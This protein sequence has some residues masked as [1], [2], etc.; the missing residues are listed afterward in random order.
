[1][2]NGVSQA[3]IIRSDAKADGEMSNLSGQTKYFHSAATATHDSM[4]SLCTEDAI[5]KCRH[6]PTR[7]VHSRRLI[8][9]ERSYIEMSP[10]AG[11]GGE[12]A[13][14]SFAGLQPW[15]WLR[16]SKGPGSD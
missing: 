12:G 14:L 3:E 10:D 4:C 7:I 8:I 13:Q 15:P 16:Q 1:V 9:L 11:G 6:I 5:L 2:R